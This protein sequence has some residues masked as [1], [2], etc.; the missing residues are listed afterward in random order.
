LQESLRLDFE[1]VVVQVEDVRVVLD[2]V[3][4]RLSVTLI[5]STPYAAVSYVKEYTIGTRVIDITIIRAYIYYTW[6]RTQT[7][8]TRKSIGVVPTHH[9]SM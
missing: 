1:V 5:H 9:T 4:R 3:S 7:Q 2:H 8:A 6:E